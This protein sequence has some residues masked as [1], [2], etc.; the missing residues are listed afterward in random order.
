VAYDRRAGRFVESIADPALRGP[1]TCSITTG[2]VTCRPAFERYAELCRAYPP[3]RVE[4]ITGVRA[5]QIVETARLLWERRPASY[6]HWTGLE[7]HTNA[8]QTV[9]AISLLYALTGSVEAPGANVHPARPAVNDLAPLSLLAES[10]RPKAI[11][12]SQ[13]P[14]GPGRQSWVTAR[15]VYR[16]I[17]HDNPY[18]VRGMIGFGSNLLLSQPDPDL[19]RAALSRLDFLVYADLFLTPTASLADIVLPVAS[20]WERG[21]L[22]V[23]FGP[24][25]PGEAHIQ[26]RAPVVPPRGEARSDIRIVCELASRLGLGAQFF[27][28]D[29]EAGH[30]WVLEPSGVT[31]EELKARPEG[32]R[33]PLEPRYWRYAAQAADGVTGFATPSRRVEIYAQRFLE[34]GQSPLPDYVPPAA[35]LRARPERAAR[36][37]LGLTSAKWVQ[38]CHSQHRAL[39]SLRGQVPDPLVEIHPAA[40]SARDIGEHDWV[41]VETPRGA[42]RARARFNAAMAPDVVCAQFGWWQACDP[43]GLPGYAV[44]GPASANYN[45]AIGTE[46]DDPI[47]GAVPLRSYICEV[48]RA[49]APEP[50]PAAIAEDRAGA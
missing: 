27:G 49:A 26:L 12:L 2:A 20:A 50:E 8:T 28:G 33:L 44:D 5:S 42:M 31:L 29:E 30:R 16:A 24:S 38:F 18:P 13:R 32:V 34:H 19:A 43:L 15:D 11:G 1:F 48:R 40:A 25:L 46:A 21:G 35:S 10:Q 23:G 47:S 36:Y 14:L 17:L 9:R 7:Q 45:G 22:R 3:E 6:F 41:V 39:P 4:R 37:P